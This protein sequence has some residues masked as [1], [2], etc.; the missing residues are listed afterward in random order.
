MDLEDSV[1]NRL[2]VYKSKS[3]NLPLDG[4]E[5]YLDLMEKITEILNP[6]RF[7]HKNVDCSQ[8]WYQTKNMVFLAVFLT[9]VA[10]D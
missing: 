5:K 3:R 6:G 4:H 9:I 10:N 2:Q 7:T 1:E 8:I